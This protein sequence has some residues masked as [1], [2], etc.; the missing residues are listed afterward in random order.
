MNN[1]VA[2][3][4]ICPYCGKETPTD[5]V[6]CIHCGG[7][8]R[9]CRAC[10][11]VNG[12]EQAFCTRCG[13]RMYEEGQPVPA[14]YAQPQPVPPSAP[15]ALYAQPQPVP[16]AAPQALYAQPPAPPY[17]QPAQPPQAGAAEGEPVKHK[18]LIDL[19]RE[20]GAPEVVVSRFFFGSE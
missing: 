17:A 8:Y 16:P 12:A 1:N 10:G 14:A 20:S 9:V 18:F 5:G 2:T 11:A 13:A 6:C 15:Q 7:A 4:L 19:W 3:T